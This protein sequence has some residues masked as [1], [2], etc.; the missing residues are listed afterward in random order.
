MKK[1]DEIRNYLIEELN[2]NVLLRKKQ[3]KV[4]RVLNYIE[5]SLITISTV[6]GCISICSIASLVGISIGITS[7]AISVVICVIHISQ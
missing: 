1:I 3:K 7:P 2:R 6:T 5:H 4:C